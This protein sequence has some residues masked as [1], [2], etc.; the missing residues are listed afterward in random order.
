MNKD[1][2]MR[3]SFLLF[4]FS[5]VG[6]AQSATDLVAR[7]EQIFNQSCASGTC[8]V[9]KGGSGGSAPRLAA[10]GFDE[11]YLTGVL[12]RGVPGTAMPAFGN[13]LP[14]PDIAAVIAYVDTLNGITPSANAAGP[15][16][17]Q[18]LSPEAEKGRVL[19]FDA[20]LAFA[21]CSTCHQVG[22]RGN[23]V[24]SPITLVP[25]DVAALKVLKTPHV[26]TAAANGEIMPV[27][28]L[29]RGI[30]DTLFYDLTSAPP[31]LRTMDAAAVKIDAGSQW[32]HASVI[33]AYSDAELASILAYLRADR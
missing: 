3:T 5:A 26:S 2:Q 20:T 9:S 19:F 32:N 11:T 16:A 14:R 1:A 21:R 29:R 10:R 7:G 28:V 33:H 27:L 30:K 17:R 4:A 25:A 31:V 15:S 18:T 6:G 24:A 22:D 23:P 8:H 12:T 13:Q